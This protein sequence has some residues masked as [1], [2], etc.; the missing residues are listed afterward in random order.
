MIR[1]LNEKNPSSTFM[2]H[3]L[4]CFWCMEPPYEKLEGGTS[5]VS[6]YTGGRLADPNYEAVSSR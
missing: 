1:V 4:E 5:A 2:S 3:H 6:G